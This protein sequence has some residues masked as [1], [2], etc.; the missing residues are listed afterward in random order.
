MKPRRFNSERRHQTPTAAP[1]RNSGSQTPTKGY[2][3][4]AEGAVELLPVV[5]CSLCSKPFQ[6]GGDSILT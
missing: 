4:L 2:K 5:A 3:A 1:R 6:P